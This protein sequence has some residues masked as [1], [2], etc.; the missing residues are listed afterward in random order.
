M[1]LNEQ[2]KDKFIIKYNRKKLIVSIV[3]T[4]IVFL[5]GLFIVYNV[6]RVNKYKDTVLPNSYLQEYAIGDYSYDSLKEFINF[7]NSIINDK[8][9]TFV[10]DGKEYSYKYS[11]IGL[12]LNSEKIVKEIELYQNDLSFSKKLKVINGNKKKVYN[13]EFTYSSDGVREFLNNLKGTVDKEREDGRFVDDGYSISYMNGTNGFV[14]NVDA[15]YDNFIKLLDEG[16]KDDTK[17]EL[18]GDVSEAINNDSY[19]TVDTMVSSFT[20]EFNPYIYARAQNLYTAL[21]YING[22]VIAP[23]ET[24]SYYKYAGPYNK[25]GY[26]FYYEFVGNGVCQIATTTYNAALLG[27]LEIVKRYPHAAK[28]VYVA[29][30]LDATVASYSS[31]WNVDM[32]W[33]NTYDYPIYIKAYAN[34]GKATVEF[35]SNHDA[36][37]GY[38]YE[39]ESVQIGARGYESYL[40]V[41]KDG[42]EVEKRFIARTWYTKDQ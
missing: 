1:K 7:L 35:W 31:G 38:T 4:V 13:Y 34:N 9:V 21:G 11:E 26:V 17:I 18:V 15:S 30:G 36:K 14:M 28:S 39:T 3:L 12:Y 41:Y 10:A 25:R 23:G 2:F 33:K 6:G 37:K 32:Q 27:G 19:A 20:T 42:V 22:A 29:G 16:L 24:F 5:I 40:H 8:K